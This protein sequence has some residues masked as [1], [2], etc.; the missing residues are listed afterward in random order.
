MIDFLYSLKEYKIVLYLQ[1]LLY[2]KN[3]DYFNKNFQN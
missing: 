2:F 1:C 3:Y